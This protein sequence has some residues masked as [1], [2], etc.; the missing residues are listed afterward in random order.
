MD[1]RDTLKLAETESTL[2][3]A[4]Q[5]LNENRVVSSAEVMT[6]PSITRRWC[7]TDGS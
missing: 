6:I 7:L 2:W 1:P 4:A 3:A 5:I